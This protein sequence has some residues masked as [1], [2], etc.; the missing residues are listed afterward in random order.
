MT[1]Y[2]I[3]IYILYLY[4][5]KEVV[6]VVDNTILTLTSDANLKGGISASSIDPR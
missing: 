4:P 3:I 6:R 5:T 1:L 2:N